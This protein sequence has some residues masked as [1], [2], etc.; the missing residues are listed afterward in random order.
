VHCFVDDW[1]LNN[2]T[3]WSSLPIRGIK[4][5][6]NLDLS[7]SRLVQNSEK[8]W[9]PYKI[10]SCLLAS[11]LSAFSDVLSTFFDVFRRFSTF[12]DVFRRF[13]DVF[14]K[15]FDVFGVFF[16]FKFIFQC[17]QSRPQ[18]AR[19]AYL[20]TRET[21]KLKKDKETVGRNKLKLG[22]VAQWTPQKQT[23]RVQIPPVFMENIAMLL[24]V[25][26]LK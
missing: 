7:Q 24:C 14:P 25:L 11:S 15:F 13:F 6:N 19:Y 4:N 22:G 9:Q 10:C 16:F 18:G 26:D 8:K 3:A 17:S 1:Q 12:F 21:R 2:F 23:T 20:L 5:S